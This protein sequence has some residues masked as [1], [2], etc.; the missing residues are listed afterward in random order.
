MKQFIAI[1][2]LV[3]GLSA[4]EVA[5]QYRYPP[6]PVIFNVQVNRP[7]VNPYAYGYNRPVPVVVVPVAPVPYNYAY[8]IYNPYLPYGRYPLTPFVGGYYYNGYRYQY[9]R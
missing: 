4:G 8:P 2:C 1:A 3:I 5:A 7:Y 6:R 9:L